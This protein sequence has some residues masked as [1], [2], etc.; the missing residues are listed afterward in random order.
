MT[1]LVRAS[2]FLAGFALAQASESP[3]A[4][5]WRG[6]SIC[7]TD[8]PSCRNETVVYYIKT[9]PDKPH[10]LSVQADKIV[11]GKAITMG[12]GEWEYDDAAKTLVMGSP[13]RLWRLMLDGD[14]IEGTLTLSDGTAFRKMRLRK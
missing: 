4:G 2:L 9:V 12:S 10:V 1:T 13:Q 7:A 8:A 3:L 11:D 6:E 14:Q 5:V